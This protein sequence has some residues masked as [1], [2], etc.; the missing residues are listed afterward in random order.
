MGDAPQP[1]RGGLDDGRI[2]FR[3][4][5]EPVSLQ[6]KA[7][8]RKAFDGAL[9]DVLHQFDFVIDSQV[10][11][12]VDWYGVPR[13]RWQTDRYPDLDNWL[14]PLIDAFVGADRLLVDDSLVRSVQ[15]TWHEGMVEASSIHVR[16]DF[17]G[18]HTLAKE[19]L[20]YA[21]FAAGLCFPMPSDMPTEAVAALVDMCRSTLTALENLEALEVDSV[22]TW[23][24]LANGWIHRSRLGPG[25][26]VVPAA[27]L[28]T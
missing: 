9:R 2:D 24:L 6:S 1:R 13:V 14:K 8:A 28:L 16:L 7:F 17:D 11:L 27:D 4:D 15:L 26:S 22:H 25:F 20:R 5:V 19:S 18:D 10:I 12:T 21:Q 3:V 23:P